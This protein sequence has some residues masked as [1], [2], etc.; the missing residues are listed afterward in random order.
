MSQRQRRG[1]T[2]RHR[3]RIRRGALRV[4]EGEHRLDPRP[5]LAQIAA[6]VPE[7]P[8][9]GDQPH[10]DTRFTL[11]MRPGQRRPEIVVF[12]I[13]MG[14]P[15]RVRLT[16][17]IRPAPCRESEKTVG[18]SATHGGDLPGRSQA[19]KAIVAHGLQHREACGAAARLCLQKA[20]IYQ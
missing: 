20:L 11:L 10:P 7:S 12:R 3:P 19:L 14:Q 8:E 1:A 2:E 13:N 16:D 6:R 15:P 4:I 5:P 9:G 17:G 18:M